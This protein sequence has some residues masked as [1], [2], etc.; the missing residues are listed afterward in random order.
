[1]K[2]MFQTKNNNNFYYLKELQWSN[3]AMKLNKLNIKMKNQNNFQNKN[4]V[5]YF[6]EKSWNKRFIYGK[7]QNYDSSKDKNVIA[8]ISK[9]DDFNCYHNAIKKND[10]IIKNFYSNNKNNRRRGVE[11]NKT[12]IRVSLN[13][14]GQNIKKTKIMNNSYSNNS[15]FPNNNIIIS[16]DFIQ[17]KNELKDFA[18]L[19]NNNHNSP[20]KLSKIW[21]DLC[22]LEPYRELFNILITQL[23]DKGKEDFCEREFNELYEL[24]ADLQVLSSSVY[25]RHK[26]L[27]NLNYLND[28]LGAILRSKQNTSNEIVLKKISK[29]IE[30]LREHTVNICFLMQ[31]IKFKINQGHRWGKYD[32]DA[33]SE[34]FKFDKNY[35][36][37]M[38]EEMYVL[39]EGYAKYFFNIADDSN[40]FLLNASEPVDKKNKPSDPFFRYVPLSDEMRENINQCNYIIY[41]ELIGYQNTNVSEN[42]FR[43]ISPLK[44]Y[45][46]TDI[47]I[48]T[49]KKYN[50]TYTSTI[51]NSIF[52]LSNTNNLWIKKGEILSPT[53]TN[54][55]YMQKSYNIGSDKINN[56]INMN[57]NRLSSGN[58]NDNYNFNK[59]YWKMDKISND[60]EDKTT[61]Y[62]NN[63]IKELMLDK[64]N[65]NIEIDINNKKNEINTRENNQENIKEEE[66]EKGDI[67]SKKEEN[68]KFDEIN[69]NNI[70]IIKK[71]D[72]INNK[73][74]KEYIFNNDEINNKGKSES[75]TNTNTNNANFMKKEKDIENIYIDS[76]VNSKLE[77]II[78]EE[79]I[80]TESIKNDNL[81]KNN[82]EE[83]VNDNQDNN[84]NI[85]DNNKENNL[86]EDREDN[87]NQ[88][89]NL[90]D[91]YKDNNNNNE[92]KSEEF[93]DLNQIKSSF[94]KKDD[95]EFFVGTIDDNDNTGILGEQLK[96]NLKDDLDNKIQSNKSIP[97]VI[98]KNIHISIFDDD[99]TI[100]SK[101][102]YIS[103]YPCI[104][105]IIK[106]MFK[107]EE[108]IIPNILTGFSPYLLLIHEQI[109][110]PKE[111]INWINLKNNIKGLCIFSFDYNKGIIKLNINHLSIT[112]IIKDE[113]IIKTD[114]EPKI[115]EQL[116]HIFCTIIEYIK[117][118]FYFDEIIIGYNSDKANDNILNIFLNDLNFVIINENENEE[119]EEE[120]TIKKDDNKDKN[121]DML[122]KMIYTNDSTKNR[123][124]DLVR[125]SILRYI[126]KN[127]LDIFD[128]ELITNSTELINLDKG[129][130]NEVNMLNI[131]LMRYL[132]DK[133]EK[134]NIQRLY[135]KISNLDQIIKLFQINNIDNNKE[136]PLSLAENRFDILCTVIN[137][138]SYNNYFSSSTFFNNYNNNYSNS[139]LDKNTGIFYNF[140]KVDKLLILENDKYNIKFYQIL[141]RNL[142][143]FFCKINDEFYKYLNK[144]N[145]YTQINNIYKDTLT[146]N[147]KHVLDNKIIWVPCF[148]AYKHLK[149]LTNNS[150]GTVH[151][152]IKITNQRIKQT[153]KEILRIN[154]SNKKNEKCFIKIEPEL[155][156]DIILDNDFIFGIIN[157]TGILSEKIFGKVKKKENNDEDNISEDIEGEEENKEQPYVIFLSYVK[158]NDFIVDNI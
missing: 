33:I 77:E 142:S 20:D 100:F 124:N 86:I 50:D 112:N 130:K 87:N 4:P 3:E 143:L 61:N 158:K 75:K 122:N 147:K 29:K 30:N 58:D 80:K 47:D 90:N 146:A 26:I 99:I 84:L 155:S 104:P 96:G 51:N 66:K 126:G 85:I 82:K 27:E 24:K 9:N 41:Q 119:I 127:I 92:K 123:V 32:L 131:I 73:S 8:N 125:Q 48:K 98:S 60:I 16:S 89:N 135:N 149:N 45:K 64:N 34:K 81:D 134:S 62:I 110:N 157:N 35:L 101:D 46:Y 121:N 23:S 15:I 28:R 151:E 120:D 108:N 5:N 13:P 88:D 74:E 55:S 49:Y 67:I 7:I 139:Y 56:N 117:K 145:T 65:M 91:D 59:Y 79:K 132:L 43:N 52:S 148:E 137:K 39:K 63:D 114:I 150:V 10:I 19:L 69:I 70:S 106:N 140:F 93:K 1:M 40:P 95:D 14:M 78:E 144:S 133:N 105:Q 53:R 136:L 11:Y 37:K 31:K 12:N 57:K 83:E 152:Y 25:H 44:K 42:N 18:N 109:S 115:L 76:I 72:N 6:K 71:K 68:E 36:I 107:I 138:I 2:K 111:Q 94:E 102:F 22:I 97:K 153:S 103:F 54:Y 128:L 116:K 156:K 129:K 21:N 154:A 113:D 38:K 17:N 141:N 118:N